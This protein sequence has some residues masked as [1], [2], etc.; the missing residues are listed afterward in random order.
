MT[1]VLPSIKSIKVLYFKQGATT[2]C[3]LG[4]SAARQTEPRLAIRLSHPVLLHHDMQLWLFFYDLFV[5]Q[6]M[7]YNSDYST[8][9]SARTERERL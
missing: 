2:T 3:L 8:T 5:G 9:T 4:H 1:K 6:R 7:I